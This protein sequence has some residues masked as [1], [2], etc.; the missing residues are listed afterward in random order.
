LVRQITDDR[1]VNGVVGEALGVL[2][3]ADRCQPL[4]KA[5]HGTPVDVVLH[6]F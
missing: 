5:F 6:H 4:G 2:T 1:E 3:Q